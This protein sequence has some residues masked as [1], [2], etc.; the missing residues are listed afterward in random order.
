[1]QK[2]PSR[3]P[4]KIG[5]NPQL[6]HPKFDQNIYA[7]MASKC[8]TSL[9]KTTAKLERHYPMNLFTSAICYWRL[10]I[11]PPPA[12]WYVVLWSR[13]PSQASSSL[14]KPRQTKNPTPR[15]L[16]IDFAT[17]RASPV[18]EAPTRRG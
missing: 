9:P 2:Q 17:S 12:L 16:P 10:A 13:R 7:R 4:R 6:D 5:R 3:N 8:P 18:R 11:V 14:V 15:V 1:M